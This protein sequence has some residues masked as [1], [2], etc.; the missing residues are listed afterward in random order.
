LYAE[1]PPAG[2]D[3][4]LDDVT[5]WQQSS[6][7]GPN[8]LANSTFETGTANWFGFG[9]VTVSA[10]TDRAHSG[11]QSGRVSGRTA[12][13]NGLATNILGLVTPG[14]TYQANGFTQV[15]VPSAAGVRLTLQSAC[16]GGAQSFTQIATVTANNTTWTELN[17]AITIPN[18]NLTTAVF[19]L[20]NAPAGVDMYLDDV[21]LRAIP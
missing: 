10:A 7:L 3:I 8:V 19:Y 1:G 5:F 20:E 4:L 18:C 2:V 14:R 15:S 11:A 9:S 16:D 13:W 17:G 6:G 12:T 21:T